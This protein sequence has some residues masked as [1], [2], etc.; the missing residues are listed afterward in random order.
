[1][2]VIHQIEYWVVWGDQVC[3]L[4]RTLHGEIA[5]REYS[6]QCSSYKLI[7]IKHSCMFL[8]ALGFDLSGGE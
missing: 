1:M 5:M 4:I 2:I 7:F 8:A 6:F 3:D